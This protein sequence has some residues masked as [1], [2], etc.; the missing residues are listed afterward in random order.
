[1][2]GLMGWKLRGGGS[3]KGWSGWKFPLEKMHVDE[4]R[5]SPGQSLWNP[6]INPHQRRR[7]K[8]CQRSSQKN[9]KA[10]C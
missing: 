3:L 5:K 6:N 10:K 8:R 1:M 2:T 7:S 4:M 9:Q